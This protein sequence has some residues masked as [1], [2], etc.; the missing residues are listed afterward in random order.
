MADV[1]PTFGEAAD[2]ARRRALPRN[3][4]IAG[5]ALLVVLGFAWGLQITL[6][7]AAAVSPFGAGAGL[8]ALLAPSPPHARFLA[9]SALT[10]FLVPLSAIMAASRCAS[11]GLIVLIESPPPV[12]T[13][14]LAL[15]L[16]GERVS[17][18][19]AAEGVLGVAAALDLL[20]GEAAPASGSGGGSAP[21][22]PSLPRGR[23]VSARPAGLSPRLRGRSR[24][25]ASRTSTPVAP[26][27]GAPSAVSASPSVAAPCPV[28]S[29]QIVSE[30]RSHPVGS[31]GARR[32]PPP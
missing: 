16:G 21:S 23:I 8:A 25:P 32:A 18:E 7:K 27:A 11:T 4:R 9:L 12:A 30:T 15:A 13:I 26:I 24:H 6:M 31:A 10:G 17:P 22:S 5:F 29:M 2:Q 19:R 28:C 14:K 20:S 3:A 1:T